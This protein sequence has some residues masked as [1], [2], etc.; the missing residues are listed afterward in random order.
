M[1][2]LLVE[3]KRSGRVP[4]VGLALA[5]QSTQSIS[6]FMMTPAHSSESVLFGLADTFDL[7]GLFGEK[8]RAIGLARECA[9]AGQ[10]GPEEDGEKRE[11]HA[12]CSRAHLDINALIWASEHRD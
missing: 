10:G 9:C 4:Y 3:L 7:A 5:L 2:S 12:I 11:K 1:E 8:A 6:P